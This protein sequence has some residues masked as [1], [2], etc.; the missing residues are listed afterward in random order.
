[1]I[2]SL[3]RTTT[4][5]KLIKKSLSRIVALSFKKKKIVNLLFKTAAFAE[6]SPTWPKQ[7]RLDNCFKYTLFWQKIFMKIII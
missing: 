3:L 7:T 1:M 4:F 5:I 2:K 6:V